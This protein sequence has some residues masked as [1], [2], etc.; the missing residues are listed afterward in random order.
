MKAR[1]KRTLAVIVLLLCSALLVYLDKETEKWQHPLACTGIKVRILDSVNTG[2]VSASEIKAIIAGETGPWLG[3]K[4]DSVKLWKIEEVLEAKPVIL[5]AEAYLNGLTLNLDVR[6]RTPVVRFNSETGAFYADGEGFIFPVKEGFDPDVPVVEGSIPVSEI[7]GNFY[8]TVQDKE[9]RAWVRKIIGLAAYI[10]GTRPWKNLVGK[11]VPDPDGGLTII[12][13]KGEEKFIFGAPVDIEKKFK[14][15]E[16]YY[17]YIAKADEG[18]VYR[19]VDV[20]FRKQI[21][22]R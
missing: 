22:C 12:P 13:L 4:P 11:I 9:G 20:S 6:Q 8:G 10:S 5:S 18:K 17:Q 16:K 15:I 1:V 14:K 21:I 7:K 3:L 19:T 2:F